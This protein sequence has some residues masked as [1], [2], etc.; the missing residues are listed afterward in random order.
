[1]RKPDQSREHE[2]KHYVERSPYII[3]ANN[4]GVEIMKLNARNEYEEYIPRKSKHR[5]HKHN[6]HQEDDNIRKQ[7]L[8]NGKAES[9]KQSSL[10]ESARDLKNIANEFK[11]A[12]PERP[13]PL[14]K[15]LAENLGDFHDHNRTPSPAVNITE[16]LLQGARNRR[17]EAQDKLNDEFTEDMKYVT[18]N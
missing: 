12:E 5:S 15:Q 10:T 8:G 16:N 14:S 6:S 13:E 4:E 3:P 1:M 11:N 18:E 17:K 9:L 2:T 7:S